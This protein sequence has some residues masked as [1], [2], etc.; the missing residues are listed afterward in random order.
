MA[1][2]AFCG[3]G[4]MGGAMAARLVQAGHAVTV[5]NR[6]PGKAQAL[7]ERGAARAE[8]P[9][10]AVSGAEAAITMLADPDALEAVVFADH[11]LAEGMADGSTLIDMSTVGPDAVRH[12]RERLHRGITLIDAPVLGSAP[13]AESG[14]LQVF[15]GGPAEEV[16]R[17][18]PVLEALGT[19]LHVGPLGAGAA[20]KLVTNST[21]GALMTALGEALALADALGLDERMVLD[22]LARSPIGV[23]VNRKRE[24]IESGAYPPSFKLSLARKDLALV[25]QAAKGLDLRVAPASGSWLEAADAARLGELDYSAV[26]AHIRGRPATG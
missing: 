13:Q 14:E 26:V 17:W 6:T 10:E 1:K 24:A 22:V 9:A 15:A 19:V 20:M 5:W 7:E 2:I 21:L 23:T 25:A 3:L 4:L 12:L 18:R 8:T 11:G 16:D